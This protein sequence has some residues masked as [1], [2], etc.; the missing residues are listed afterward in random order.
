MLA[1]VAFN[2]GAPA[3]LGKD[4]LY[5]VH[6]VLAIEPRFEALGIDAALGEQ[7]GAPGHFKPHGSGRAV[8]GC[9][10]CFGRL[11]GG[12][13]VWV[14]MP[15]GVHGRQ[16]LRRVFVVEGDDLQLTGVWILMFGYHGFVG[17][18]IG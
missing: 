16:P 14:N 7:V 15:V 13:F 17:A 9:Q 4:L 6:Q 10:P 18:A 5:R 2:G 3:A 11:F 1:P 12:G 8:E